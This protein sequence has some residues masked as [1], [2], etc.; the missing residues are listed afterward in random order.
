MSW[1]DRDLREKLIVALDFFKIEEFEGLLEQIGEDLK[2]VKVGMQLYYSEGQKV[3][4]YLKNR[5]L[6]VFL[7]LKLHDI[8]NTVGMGVRSLCSLGVDMINI[9]SSGGPQVM[10]AAREAIESIDKPSRPLLIAV[11]HL[12]SVSQEMLTN[13]LGCSL[14]LEDAVAKLAA[15]SKE[16]GLD[17]VVASSLEVTRIKETC[18]REFKII[19]PGI[20]LSDGKSLDDQVRTATPDLAVQ[21]GADY[22]VVGRPITKSERPKE[23][24]YQILK[25]IEEGYER[26]NH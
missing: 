20:R 22:L 14:P 23:A 8:P 6:K 7:D 2:Y 1:I 11:T 5:G 21:N 4:R 3:V 15:F 24:F 17:G 19:V 13:H 16:C 25:K 9:H 18:G 26:K 12:T 10:M